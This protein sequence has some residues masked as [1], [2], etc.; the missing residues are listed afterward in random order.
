MF[1]QPSRSLELAVPCSHGAGRVPAGEGIAMKRMVLAVSLLGLSVVAG[2]KKGGGG[3][4]PD[5]PGT[6]DGAKAMMSEFLK[7]GADLAKLSNGLR[8]DADDYAA[9]F[10][11]EAA[12]KIKKAM[13]PAWDS[14]QMVIKGNP[15]QSEVLMASATV[16]DLKAGT[17]GAGS[18]PGGYREAAAQMKSGLT[19]HCFKFVEP[20]K[21]L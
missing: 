3:N 2:C 5:F 17:G 12:D 6:A 21:T 15:G 20:G 1:G 9:V 13:D 18:C 8:P 4:H 19:V 16:D 7:P 14:G 11:G 10:T